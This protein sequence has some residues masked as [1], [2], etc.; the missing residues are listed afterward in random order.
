[1]DYEVVVIGGGIGGLTAAAL[2]AARGVNV[3]LFERESRAGGCA[4]T[5]QKFGY[6]FEAGAG[7]YAAWEKGEIHHRVFAELPTPPPIAYPVS[8]SY[9]VRLPDETDIAIT[10]HDQEFEDTLGAAF[11]ECARAA[12]GFYREIAPIGAALRRTL[13]RLPAL[14]TASRLERWR[15]IAPEV[16][17]ARRVMAR[18]NHTAAERLM[19]TSLR[20]RRFIDVQLQI[21]A[22]CASDECAYNYAAVALMIPRRGMY[23]IR[24]GA[25]A[26]SDALTEAIKRSGG[27]VKLNAPVL[28]LASDSSGRAAGVDLLNG[29]TVRATRAVVSN[30]TVWDTY[31]KLIGINRTPAAVR[32]QL[33]ITRGWGAYLV[34]LGMHE[35]AAQRLPASHVLALTNW[36]EEQ[37]YNPETAQFMLAAAPAGDARA[38]AGFRATT[39]AA[40]TDATQWFTFHKDETE[41]EARDQA[42]LETLWQRLH[43]AMPELGGDVEVIETATPRTYYDA[44][45]RKLGMVGG[46]RQSLDAFGMNSFSHKTILNN[47]YMVGDT[48]FPGQGVAA[49]TLSGLAVADEIAPSL[50]R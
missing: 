21:F 17:V 43:V 6:E 41:H 8:P 40:F 15:A 13:L 11:P 22:Q 7:L 26:L 35:E 10:E 23:G 19:H 24:G 5:F 38:P 3:C 29:E 49:A 1:M 31:D 50:K 9:I 30:L 47:L 2:L 4:A 44:T 20:F 12:I 27:T 16:S 36:Q 28:R 37:A 18:M 42:T 39:V 48:T 45:R 34:Y 14:R 46:I 32:S 25:S 33:K